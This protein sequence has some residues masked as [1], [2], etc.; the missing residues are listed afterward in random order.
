MCSLLTACVCCMNVLEDLSS[1]QLSWTAAVT[2]RLWVW[3][4]LFS[5]G[6]SLRFLV[7]GEGGDLGTESCPRGF[8]EGL[9]AATI[10]CV[11][12]CASRMP[13]PCCLHA[14]M[15]VCMCPCMLSLST[16][17]WLRAL[18]PLLACAGV[19]LFSWPLFSHRFYSHSHSHQIPH[20]PET[21]RL[22]GVL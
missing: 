21:P 6:P 17:L 15:L 13:I 3:T 1:K 18:G 11:A 4:F 5:F 20:G 19:P 10:H 12:S 8:M 9:P 16:P 2:A 22:Q 7:Q 14:C